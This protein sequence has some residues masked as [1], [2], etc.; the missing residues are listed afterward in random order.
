MLR[1]L[2]GRREIISNKG[3]QLKENRQPQRA[4]F[5]AGRLH[6]RTPALLPV[7]AA[8]PD[9]QLLLHAVASTH[10]TI[11][12]LPNRRRQWAWRGGLGAPSRSLGRAAGEGAQA[13]ASF[14]SRATN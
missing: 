12:G 2:L 4:G 1:L 11:L 7:T 9:M 6:W 5:Y 10:C 13:F 14:Q 8:H 3:P